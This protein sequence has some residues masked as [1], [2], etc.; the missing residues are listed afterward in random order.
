MFLARRAPLARHCNARASLFSSPP[1]RHARWL[2][3]G[4]GYLVESTEHLI[5]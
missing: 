4:G 5:N 3:V 1:A 2:G